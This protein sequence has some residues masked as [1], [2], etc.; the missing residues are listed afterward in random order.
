MFKINILR[1]TCKPHVKVNMCFV[2][3]WF[4]SLKRCKPH[5]YKDTC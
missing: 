1:L 3:M 2:N 5:V 4:S